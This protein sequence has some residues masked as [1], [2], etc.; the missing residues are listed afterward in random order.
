ME[1][2]LTV[3][4]TAMFLNTSTTT[5]YRYVKQN[6]LPHIRL[7]LGLRFRLPDLIEWI[8]QGKRKSI[9]SE[10]TLVRALKIPPACNTYRAEGGGELPKSKTKTRLNFGYGAIYIRR[11]K[12]GHPRFYIDYLDR[13]GK[14]KQRLTKSAAS[15]AEANVVLKN[16][17]LQELSKECGLSQSIQRITFSELSEM[18]IDN[19]AKTN[20]KSWKDD[21]YRL[22]AH[23]IPFFGKLELQEINPLIIE[24]YRTKRLSDGVSKSTV[25][26]ETTIL[27]KMFNLAIDWNHANVNPVQKVKFFSEKDTGIERILTQEEETKLM[28]DSPQHL[29]SILAFAL[30][31]GMRRGEI[32]NLKWEHV[33]LNR[34]TIRVVN[35]KSSRNRTIPINATLFNILFDS[36]EGNRESE[37]VF[38]NPRTGKPYTEVK[39]SFKNACKKAEIKDLRFHD[40]RHTFASRLIELGVDLIT[41]RDLLGHASV[42]VTQRYVHSG[43]DQKRKAVEILA[44]KALQ[45]NENSENLLHPRYIN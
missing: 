20:K 3:R 15:W 13:S 39:N 32:F 16:A 35:T 43:Q 11:T 2:L 25:N 8:D 40:L 33:D 6:V 37:Y 42:K 7:R 44:E 38:L 9:Y 41:V 22:D 26:R 1:K 14:R 19:Y 28:A 31:T 24:K 23:M 27:T 30:N 12:E 45:R 10:N 21:K 4:E 5:V 18:Y 29:R 17:V 34:K 36:R